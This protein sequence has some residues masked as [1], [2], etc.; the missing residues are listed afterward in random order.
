MSTHGRTGITR[1]TMGS[2]TDKVLHADTTPLL[3]IRAQEQADGAA[4]V[5]LPAVLDE[6]ILPL[7]GSTL[8]EGIMPYLLPLVIGLDLKVTLLRI[9]APPEDYY[10]YMDYPVGDYDNLVRDVDAL[11]LDYLKEVNRKFK[12]QGVTK[13]EERL[14]HG[15]A[16]NAIIELAEKT[17]NNLVALATHGRSGMGRWLL[18]SVADRVVQHSGDPVLII[19]AS[20][21]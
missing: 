21:D 2:V 9:T 18:G 19:R 10:R 1:W 4:P 15:H 11:A 8:A 5:A 3:V 12:A 17:P 14:F 7:D 6:V 16:A 20:E 13:V